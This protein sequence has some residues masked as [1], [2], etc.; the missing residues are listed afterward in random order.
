[1]KRFTG[2]IRNICVPLMK[3]GQEEKRTSK[4]WSILPAN[5]KTFTRCSLNSFYLVPNLVIEWY[6]QGERCLTPIHYSPVQGF[7]VSP[8]FIIGLA[9]G[10][11]PN[12]R[13]IDGESDLEEERATFLCRN[14]TGG[15][16]IAPC[17]PYAFNQNGTPV[18]LM[19]SRFIKEIDDS[20]YELVNVHSSFGP[21]RGFLSRM[22]SI[23]IQKSLW[24]WIPRP[25]FLET[26]FPV[27]FLKCATQVV[28]SH[29]FH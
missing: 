2:G 17:I 27:L 11:F 23:W 26:S 18:R 3:I 24:P 25:L 6:A 12:K 7:G 1:M 9:D 22:E 16:L 8:C 29:V 15:T 13:A 14:H 19:Q 20:R 28:H 10:L 21:G 5:M 4:A